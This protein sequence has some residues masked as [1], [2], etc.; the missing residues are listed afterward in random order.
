MSI[1]L[2]PVARVPFLCCFSRFLHACGLAPKFN[3]TNVL[4]RPTTICHAPPLR[5]A[6][7]DHE[8]MNPKRYPQSRRFALSPGKIFH[9]I[10]RFFPPF[11]TLRPA[12]VGTTSGQNLVIQVWGVKRDSFSFKTP[13]PLFR[14][15]LFHRS[16]VLP[17]L[18]L[19]PSPQQQFFPN[20]MAGAPAR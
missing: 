16:V 18:M 15:R 2:C 19:S 13:Q 12:V 4:A 8:R 11:R 20:S 5:S 3:G 10:P 6:F 9:Y 14:P 17:L 1:Y 7:C